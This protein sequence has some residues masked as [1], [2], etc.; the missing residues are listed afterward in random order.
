MLIDSHCHLNHKRLLH[1]GGPKKVIENANNNGVNGFLTINCRISDEFE[2]ILKIARS[3]KNVWCS[4]ATH[5]HD[6]GDEAEKSI[7]L[8]K[9]IKLSQSDNKIIAIGETGLDYHYK[10]STIEDQQQSFRK[11]I[12]ACLETKLPLIIHSREADDDIMRILKEEA[13]GTD[14]KGVFHCFSSTPKLA[15]QA[16]DFGFYLSFSGILTFKKSDELREIAKNTPLDRILLETDAPFLA[17]EPYRGE[18]CEPAHVFN[19]SCT[20]ANIHNLT[21][22]E[23][24]DQTTDNFFTL[25]NKAKMT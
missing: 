15:E 6:A 23:I 11:H 24:A 19:T 3:F 2:E 17:P 14:L 4:I 10:H 1:L 18:I 9:L 5:P 12:K 7:T 16:L 20:L 25:F 13:N 21:K 22:A 8:D